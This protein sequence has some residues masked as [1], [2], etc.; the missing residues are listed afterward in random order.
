MI[1]LYAFHLL[2]RLL[3]RSDSDSLS[4]S[5]WFLAFHLRKFDRDSLSA[6]HLFTFC[7]KSQKRVEKQTSERWFS[8]IRFG[9]CPMF[10]PLLKTTIICHMD[11]REVYNLKM[12]FFD[13][14][15]EKSIQW[16]QNNI[17]GLKLLLK[18]FSSIKKSIV[19]KC[20]KCNNSADFFSY[21]F[22]GRLH[23]S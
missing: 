7:Q 20:M 11:D 12:C 21:N 14:F 1:D 22:A 15:N 19:H 5:T 18:K 9:D 23:L 8:M 3:C 17:Q 16:S 13:N 2:T 10:L 6:W 4:L